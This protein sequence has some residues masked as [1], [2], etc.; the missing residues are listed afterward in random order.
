MVVKPY[1]AKPKKFL[2]SRDGVALV[3]PFPFPRWCRGSRKAAQTLVRSGVKQTAL[4]FK[5]QGLRLADHV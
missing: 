2:F 4:T 1:W 5:S 3:T